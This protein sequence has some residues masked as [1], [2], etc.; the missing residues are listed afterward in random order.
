MNETGEN[1]GCSGSWDGVAGITRVDGRP[2]RR[3]FPAQQAAIVG[4]P[5]LR[6]E[7]PPKNLYNFHNSRRR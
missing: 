1:K 3:T 4:T 7:A 6:Q 5:E 2:G